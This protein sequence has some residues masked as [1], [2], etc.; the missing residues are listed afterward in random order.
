MNSSS[1]GPVVEPRGAL[2]RHADAV[3]RA[4][5]Y[6]DTELVHVSP[7]ELAKLRSVLGPGTINPETGLEEH[8]LD[9]LLGDIGGAIS[10]AADWLFGG[11]GGG[12]GASGG[13]ASLIASL[14]G[15]GPSAQGPTYGNFNPGAGAGGLGP[16]TGGSGGQ[17]FFGNKENL[18]RLINLA[19]GIA[20]F[21]GAL[22]QNQNAAKQQSKLLKQ[23]KRQQQSLNQHVD[24]PIGQGSVSYS[25]PRYP[26]E[27]SGLY[28][29]SPQVG[30]RRGGRP[31]GALTR[32]LRPHPQGRVAGPG[33]GQSDDVDA[34]LSRDEYVIPADVVSGIGDGSSGAGAD[35]LDHM[36]RHVRK[37]RVGTAKF[38]RSV[39]ALSFGS[40]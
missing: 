19:G 23:Q 27:L 28:S 6:R 20:S 13:I 11:S 24:Y 4:G 32:G 26:V 1:F 10:G 40:R 34:R 21:V 15:G 38:P 39:G 36:V 22:N 37:T 35:R 5:R 7:R 9:D 16:S 25:A 17:S 33:T 29:A 30:Y 12:G 31:V 14:F 2:V 8:F 18:S 3:R